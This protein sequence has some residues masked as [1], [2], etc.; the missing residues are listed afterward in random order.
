MSI[1]PQSANDY[2][3]KRHS[4][5]NLRKAAQHCRGC[6]LFQNATQTVFGEG[7]T[8]AAIMILGEV[9]GDHEDRIGWKLRLWRSRP[10]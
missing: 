10:R 2:L 9:P 3:P 5:E 1:Q 4:I 8:S 6:Q 7:A